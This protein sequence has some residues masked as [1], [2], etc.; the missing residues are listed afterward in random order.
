MHHALNDYG[1]LKKEGDDFSECT[2]WIN[3]QY[4]TLKYSTIVMIIYAILKT[5]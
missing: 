1:N 5:S 3:K 2:I 4:R